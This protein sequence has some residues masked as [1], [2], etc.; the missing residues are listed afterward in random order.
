[1]RRKLITA[2]AQMPHL[3]ATAAA[4]LAGTCYANVRSSIWHCLSPD[5]LYPV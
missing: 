1:V 3:A 4:L 2:G 5:A